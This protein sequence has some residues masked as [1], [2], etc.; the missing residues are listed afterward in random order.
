MKKVVSTMRVRQLALATEKSYSYW[1][2]YFVR[3]CAYRSPDDI[4]AGDVTRF[5]THLAVDKNVSP[6]T[7]NAAFSALVFLFRDVLA[8]PLENITARRATERHRIPVVLT[9]DEVQRVL[10]SLNRPYK[11]MVQLAWGAG[12][13][14]MEILRLRIKD[15]DFDRR[16]LT[17]REAKGRKDRITVLPECVRADLKAAVVQAT[18]YHSLDCNEGFP[19]V[20]M[21][22]ALARKYPNHAASLAWKFIFPSYKRSIDPRSKEERRHHV[23]PSALERH[24]GRA[25]KQ[26][27]IHKHVT[28]HT[29]RHTFRHTFATQLL[30]NGYDIRTV[31]EL[32]G[33]SDLKTTQ[34]Y[35]HVL[36]RGGN[37]VISPADR[38]ES[39]RAGYQ[40]DRAA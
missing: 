29:F 9:F 12:L 1:I 34:I 30:E 35:T 37:A 23:H 17:V 2:R 19:N 27:E 33:H 40:F 36:K 20:E 10:Q 32:L 24:L 16:A 11:T 4:V 15:I 14:K 25:V 13:R 18:H 38:V 8:V 39:P 28:M 26:A 21:P 31:Q 7:Q 3:Y 22:H 5:L 6:S